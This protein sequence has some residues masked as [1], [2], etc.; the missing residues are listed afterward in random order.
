MKVRRPIL[1]AGSGP[2]A[3]GE[4][5]VLPTIADTSTELTFQVRYTTKGLVTGK[6]QF[7]S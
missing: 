4:F 6:R 7:K 2:K 1:I 3:Q 5:S